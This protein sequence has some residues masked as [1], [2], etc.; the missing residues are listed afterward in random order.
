MKRFEGK[1]AIVTGGARGIGAACVARFADEGAHVYLADIDDEGAKRV[2]AAAGERVHFVHTD[3]SRLDHWEA[4]AQTALDA[5]GRVDTLVSNAFAKVHGGPSEISEDD[6]DRTLDV[7]LKATFLGVKT[8]AAALA[9]SG[10]SVV[11]VS[12]IHAHRS[13]P[14]FT[15]YAAAKG[16]LSALTRQLAAEGAPHVRCNSVAPGPIL[17]SQWDGS[18]EEGR[19]LEADRTLLGR[20]GDPEEVAAAVAFLASDDASYITGAELPVDGGFL[21]RIR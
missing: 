12:S 19:N 10:G 8:L 6:W 4:L 16:G 9:E 17:T 14:G 2:A 18:T 3:A 7:T 11:A 1:V 5:H 20:L 15:A 13:Y 21:V